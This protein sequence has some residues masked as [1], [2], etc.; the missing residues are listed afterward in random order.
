MHGYLD[1][2]VELLELEFQ[3]RHRGIGE[4]RIDRIELVHACSV[5]VNN[6]YG[7]R[8]L[9]CSLLIKRIP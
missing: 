9:T 2:G 3:P 1:D 5:R 8:L 7:N 6:S 4:G